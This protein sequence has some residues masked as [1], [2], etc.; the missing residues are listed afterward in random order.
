MEIQTL[1]VNKVKYAPYNPRKIDPDML[2]RLKQSIKT[3]GY[4]E[5]IVVNKRTM[6]VV[7]GNQRLRA[8]R[9][10]KIKEVQAVMVDLDIEHEKVLTSH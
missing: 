4:V 3:F 10:L 2:E 7:G 1:D 9:E 6:H 5:P 8:L